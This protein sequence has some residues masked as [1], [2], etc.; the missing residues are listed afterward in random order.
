MTAAELLEQQGLTGKVNPKETYNALVK[1]EPFAPVI[2]EFGE[3]RLLK[4]IDDQGWR[5][6]G[7]SLLNSAGAKV[8]LAQAR[9]LLAVTP[10]ERFD[11]IHAVTGWMEL[12]F[13][14]GH[15]RAIE[16]IGAENW[17]AEGD[18][19]LN[20]DGD[21]VTLADAAEKLKV[22]PNVTYN[23]LKD[24][25]ADWRELLKYFGKDRVVTVIQGRGW[26]VQD[27]GVIDRKGEMVLLADARAKL[28]G[29]PKRALAQED[30]EKEDLA[31][32]LSTETATQ[33]D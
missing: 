32:G 23:A 10:K 7:K 20:K 12:V 1:Q 14:F 13:Q 3:A 33:G 5:T 19:V 21:K 24:L 29:K 30:E 9:Q 16:V 22:D 27:G 11:E 2:K 28:R 6:D 15:Q 25:S 26:R 31:L 18:T 17:H 4:V 8:S